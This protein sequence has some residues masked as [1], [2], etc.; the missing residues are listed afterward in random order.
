VSR[1]VCCASAGHPGKRTRAAVK[2][3]KQKTHLTPNE[4]AE[5]L[6]VNWFTGQ[7]AS[8]RRPFVSI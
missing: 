5:L 1:Y 4:V 8:A 6:M 3:S 2:K 7:R